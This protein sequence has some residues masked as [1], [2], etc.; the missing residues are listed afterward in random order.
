LL[1]GTAH[2]GGAAGNGVVYK[3]HAD[4]SGFAVLHSFTAYSSAPA[5]NANHDGARP[6]GLLLSGNTLYGTAAER[7]DGFWGTVFR[8]TTDGSGFT[9]LHHFQGSDGSSPQAGLV[10]SG[11][12]LFGTANFGGPDG[13]GLVYK[14][15]TD[16]SGFT[17]L[18]SFNAQ[19]LPPGLTD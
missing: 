10:L 17:V 13:G 15:N 9:P 3:I 6:K 11:N 12:T 5:D 16:G 19:P 8:L 1:Y 7:G 14:V 2:A 18:H 4:G